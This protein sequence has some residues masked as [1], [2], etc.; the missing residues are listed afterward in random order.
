[1]EISVDED[2]HVHCVIPLKTGG[3]VGVPEFQ[4]ATRKCKNKSQKL[5]AAYRTLGS[6]GYG[7]G[8]FWAEPCVSEYIED[9][10]K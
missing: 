5:R 6:L 7:S 9:F 4:E 10:K 8:G 2:A 1:M 3:V